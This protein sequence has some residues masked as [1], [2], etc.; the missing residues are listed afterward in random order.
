MLLSGC[1]EYIEE[2][3]IVLRLNCIAVIIVAAEHVW[4][5]RESRTLPAFRGGSLA[6]LVCAYIISDRWSLLFSVD[7]LI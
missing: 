5:M 7:V 6:R 1:V 4:Y 3:A 2:L